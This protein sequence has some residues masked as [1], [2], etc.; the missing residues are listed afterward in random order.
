MGCDIH[1]HAEVKIAGAWHYYGEVECDR[2]YE[3]FEKIAGVRGGVADAIA[4]PR[5]VPDD[6]T[7]MTRL[8]EAQ[9]PED[10]HTKT[11]L[12]ASEIEAVAEWDRQ[13]YAARGCGKVL[14]WRGYLFGNLFEYFIRCPDDYP[15]ELEDLR[16]VIWFDN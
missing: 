5:G 4:E 8:H 15:P 11:W 16:F 3:L 2:D 10:W 9:K 7:F 1:I 13:R 12:T 14:P 6:A